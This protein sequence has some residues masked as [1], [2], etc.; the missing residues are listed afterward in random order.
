MNNRT[1]ERCGS[2]FDACIK[3][4]RF[5]SER[6][7][8]AAEESRRNKRRATLRQPQPPRPS[9]RALECKDCGT[10]DGLGWWIGRMQQP[11]SA[12]CRCH[13][14]YLAYTRRR[15]NQVRHCVRCSGLIAERYV[16]LCRA[17]AEIRPPS[18][19]SRQRSLAVRPC[20]DC[21]AM[22]SRP[23][24]TRCSDCAAAALTRRRSVAEARRRT[25]IAAGDPTINWRRLG[26]RDGW[27][28]HLCGG[29]VRNTAGIHGVPLGATVDHLVP[30][31]AGGEHQWP[32][33][34]LAH[35][36]CNLSRGA[37]G[38]VQLRLV[39]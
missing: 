7:R 13:P 5:C 30:I 26:E 6:C 4:K 9:R 24:T 17:C 10:T 2:P 23:S 27:T 15:Q 36:Q 11:G 34:A 20:S 18:P 29:K 33:V 22:F 16:R 8:R 12:G 3:T 28:C 1:C 31:A 37:G 25:I 21:G 32:N 39:G 14:C 38:A 35:R 19:P